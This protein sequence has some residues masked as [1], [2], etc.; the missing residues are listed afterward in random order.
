MNWNYIS[1]F[2]DADGSIMLVSNHTNEHPTIHLSFHNND[3]ELLLEIK[4]FIKDTISIDGRMATKHPAKPTHKVAFDLKYSGQKALS[5]ISHMLSIQKA[6]KHKIATC[7]K[8]YIEVTPRN[9]RY[10]ERTLARKHAFY[11]LFY[12]AMP[13]S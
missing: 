6:K 12:W 1:G 13:L 9:G 2:F 8:F 4:R 7:L 11:R 3:L 10:S 5:I